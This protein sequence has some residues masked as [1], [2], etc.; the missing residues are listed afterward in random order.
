[1][2][3]ARLPPPETLAEPNEPGSS[4]HAVAPSPSNF[5]LRRSNESESRIPISSNVNSNSH[6]LRPHEAVWPDKTSH[7]QTGSSLLQ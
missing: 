4:Q 6:F 5:V 1:M 2:C 3:V 7:Q